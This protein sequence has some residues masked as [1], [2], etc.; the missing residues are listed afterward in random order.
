MLLQCTAIHPM[1]IY[2]YGY[3]LSDAPHDFEELRGVDNRSLF[4]VSYGEISAI[5]SSYDHDKLLV[6]GKDIFAHQQ[7]LRHLMDESSIVPL[8]FGLTLKD[9]SAVET[10]LQ[11]NRDHLLSELHR[12]YRK[13]EMEIVMKYD[14]DDLFEHMVAKYPYLREEKAKV[15]NGR[16]VYYLGNRALKCEKFQAVLKKEKEVY[17]SK[18]EE[19]ISPWCAEFNKSR[20]PVGEMEVGTFNCLVNRERL[21]VFE[22]S[23]Y[24]AGERFAPDFHFTYNGPW[25]PQNFCNVSKIHY[26]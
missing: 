26:A 11:R 19:I 14:V 1:S 12:V 9:L 2:L 25:A 18:V 15:L 8:Q 17:A 20:V 23:I 10:V 16:L 5:V 24:E 22:R 13:V 21:K 7:I 4:L 3:T 6:R